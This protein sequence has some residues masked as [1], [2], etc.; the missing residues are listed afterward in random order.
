MNAAHACLLTCTLCLHPYLPCGSLVPPLC[1]CRVL[2]GISHRSQLLSSPAPPTLIAG[3]G[4]AALEAHVADVAS[5]S[6]TAS[7]APVAIVG[8][9]RVGAGVPQTGV[10]VRSV[11]RGRSMGGAVHS[12]PDLHL[13]FYRRGAAATAGA[14]PK[15][16]AEVGHD[17]A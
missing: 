6:G 4:L 15:G 16:T 12:P 3:T 14:Q 17:S 8:R 9:G 11:A 2:E 1:T 7:M 5:L 13:R 10:P